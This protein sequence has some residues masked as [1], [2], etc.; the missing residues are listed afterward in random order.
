MP[1][2]VVCV[3]GMLGKY[4]EIVDSQVD[5]GDGTTGLLRAHDDPVKTTGTAY[6]ADAPFIVCKQL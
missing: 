6:I 1:G 3:G 4:G 2:T 5:D